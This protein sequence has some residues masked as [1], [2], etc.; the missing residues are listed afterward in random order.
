MDKEKT[1]KAKRLV[2]SKEYTDYLKPML[3]AMVDEGLKEYTKEE[4]FDCMKRS[5][6]AQFINSIIKKIER[7]AATEIE[8]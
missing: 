8:D 1:R 4:S 2:V 7:T 6:K 3:Q 5:L